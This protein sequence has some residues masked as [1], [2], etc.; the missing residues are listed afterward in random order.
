MPYP[1][2]TKDLFKKYYET[3]G[4]DRILFG[5]DGSWFPRGFVSEY[6]DVQMRDCVELGFSDEDI[7]KIFAGNIGRGLGRY[8]DVRPKKRMQ[9]FEK[10]LR[11]T[12]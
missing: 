7:Q 4:P 12:K 3:I 10:Q 5:T 8:M 1:L 2:T 9:N 6:L 11:K